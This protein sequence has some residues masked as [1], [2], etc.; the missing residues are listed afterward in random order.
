[1]VRAALL[2]AH[3]SREAI[4]RFANV[5][6]GAA[7]SREEA[8]LGCM[9]VFMLEHEQ[10]QNHATEEVFRDTIVA[11]YMNELIAPYTFDV[12]SRTGKTEGLSPS[13]EE[14]AVGFLGSSTPFYQYYTDFVALYDSISFSHPLFSRLLLPP[15]SLRYPIDYR[16]HLW[17]DFSHVV[18]TIRIPIDQLVSDD[19]KEYL[20]P[21]ERDPQMVGTYLRALIKHGSSLEGFVRFVAIHHVACN[22]WPDLDGISSA[23]E[24]RASK[25]FKAVVDQCEMEAVR[26]V[27]KYRQE[28][29]GAALLPPAC[30]DR[31]GTDRLEVIE[32]LGG[33]QLVHRL[34]GLF[35]E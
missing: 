30:F 3:I 28:K 21:V 16:K 15:T 2:L 25:L 4:R 20:W 12:A 1:M 19:I 32:R 35:N 10:D 14:V 11:R 33:P 27:V 23:T 8:I 26:E 9:N 17:D 24:E 34:E 13:L 6:S 18:R 31:A 29:F 5:L 7:L 22:I